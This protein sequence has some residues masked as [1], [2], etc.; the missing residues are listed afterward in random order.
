MKNQTTLAVRKRAI[1]SRM[2]GGALSG[3]P[4]HGKTGGGAATTTDLYTSAD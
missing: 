3:A 4:K 2:T 1:S